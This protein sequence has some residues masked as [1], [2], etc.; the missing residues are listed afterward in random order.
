MTSQKTVLLVDDDA[1]LLTAIRQWLEGAGY[2]VVS[3]GRFEDARAYLRSHAPDVVLSD[4]RLGAFNGL[5]LAIYLAEARPATAVMLMSGYDD[6]VLR[7][8]ADMCGARFFLKPL[9]REDL[10]AGIE[11]AVASRSIPT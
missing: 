7:R 1:Q 5:Q 9:D 11:Q 3:C 10:L 4:V 8:D 6:P 2:Q